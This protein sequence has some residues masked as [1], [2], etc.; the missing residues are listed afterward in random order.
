[1]D[2]PHTYCGRWHQLI[3]QVCLGRWRTRFF[4][5]KHANQFLNS[6]LIGF[7]GCVD[8]F[9]RSYF[10]AITR[11][12][13]PR[14]RRSNR[15][16]RDEESPAPGGGRIGAKMIKSRTE[17]DR[18]WRGEGILNV[19]RWENRRLCGVSRGREGMRATE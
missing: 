14:L 12:R 4:D 10:R 17:G 2:S 16:R 6:N 11:S 15:K 5:F 7:F 19:R 8:H 9:T 18:F 13:S 3:L 1:M